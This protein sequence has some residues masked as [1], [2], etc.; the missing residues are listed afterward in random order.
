MIKTKTGFVYDKKLSQ[1]YVGL[2][3]IDIEIMILVKMADLNEIKMN[4][5]RMKDFLF[6]K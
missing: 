6:D 5:Y 4:S 1:S 3:V 2:N